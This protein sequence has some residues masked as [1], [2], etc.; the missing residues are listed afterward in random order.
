LR[1]V[2][3]L[4]MAAAGLLAAL[5]VPVIQALFERNEFT[6]ADTAA[7][8]QGLFFYAFAVPIWGGLQVLSRAFYATR[9][10]WTPVAVGT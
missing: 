8:A 9:D 2:L 6:P 4:S 10:M 1:Y 7:S 3:V 5:T